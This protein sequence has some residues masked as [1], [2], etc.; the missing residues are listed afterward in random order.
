MG[1]LVVEKLVSQDFTAATPPYI[2]ALLFT[3]VQTHLHQAV[4]CAPQQAALQLA[5]LVMTTL[6]ELTLE[7]TLFLEEATLTV[8]STEL[9][10]RL[11]AL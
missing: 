2:V 7:A 6:V 1:A 8:T 3:I 5:Y 4:V 11:A 10:A 9:V